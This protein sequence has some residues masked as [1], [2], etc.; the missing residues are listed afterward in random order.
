MSAAGA[1][2]YLLES[3]GL[4]ALRAAV[5]VPLLLEYEA[6]LKRDDFL[7]RAEASV[8]DIDVLLDQLAS[9]LVQV[10][11]WYLWRPQLRDRDDDMVLETAANA[12]ATHIVT[13]NLH[14]FGNIPLR[15]G[16]ETCRPAEIARKLRCGWVHDGPTP[17]VRTPSKIEKPIAIQT[18]ARNRPRSWPQESKSVSKSNYPLIAPES[19]LAAARR[20][21]RRDGVSLNQFINTALAE[22]VAALEAEEVFTKRAARANKARFLDVLRRIGP[23]QPRPGDELPED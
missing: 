9:V 2:R 22:K 3:V 21:A 18:Q 20:A 8:E 4:G 1:S 13:F 11:I 16:I 10:D 6:V 17:K 14:D 19:I 7:R 15:F 12:G 5:S 23:E